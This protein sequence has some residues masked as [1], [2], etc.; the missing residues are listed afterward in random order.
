MKAIRR[1]R[2]YADA[3]ADVV[4]VEAPQSE[5]ELRKIIAE[6]SDVPVLINFIEGGKT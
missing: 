4:F 1:A 6:L 5:E 2:S 3:G